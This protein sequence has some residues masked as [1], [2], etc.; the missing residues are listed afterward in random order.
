MRKDE[1]WD[2]INEIKENLENLVQQKHM[3]LLEKH[4]HLRD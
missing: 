2:E 4:D 1:S 3:S